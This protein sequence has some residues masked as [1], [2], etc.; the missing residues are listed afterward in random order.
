[1]R[2]RNRNESL[3]STENLIK[4]ENG[5]NRAGSLSS[6]S[7]LHRDNPSS[8]KRLY[9]P[10]GISAS[11]ASRAML[12]ARSP[13]LA[14]PA[15]RN[16]TAA[17]ISAFKAR[18]RSTVGARPG[19]MGRQRLRIGGTTPSSVGLGTALLVDRLSIA[20]LS[21]HL[22]RVY[23]MGYNSPAHPLCLLQR[24]PPELAAV[25][26]ENEYA[27]HAQACNDLARW[28]SWEVRLAN[29]L[30]FFWLPGALAFEANRRA[31]HVRA[32]QHHHRE[33]D[34]AFLRNTR[35]RALGN[36]VRFGCSRDNN[37]AY[38]D[39]FVSDA[40]ED[41]GGAPVGQPREFVLI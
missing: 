37:L 30:R 24:V 14:S 22:H 10:R 1:M 40:S 17:R 41:T 16:D 19:D 6:A 5:R 9:A 20:D 38:M 27:T 34:H 3:A 21:R 33:Y 15:F 29:F 23:F 18:G 35:A 39:V 28:R 12:E 31:A 32:L 11:L 36:C 7:P 4:G 13:D 25:V 8:P 2:N 26:N